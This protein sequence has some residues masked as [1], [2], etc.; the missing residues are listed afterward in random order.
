MESIVGAALSCRL[1]G[2]LS[3]ILCGALGADRGGSSFLVDVFASVD[4][5]SKTV[6]LRV[7]KM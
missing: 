7:S 1:W 2:K 5:M 3:G 4:E 6:N